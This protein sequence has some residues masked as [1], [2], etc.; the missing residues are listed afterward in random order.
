MM[1]V[2]EAWRARASEAL[3][4]LPSPPFV[5]VHPSTSP[6]PIT[7]IA[8]RPSS[9]FAIRCRDTGPTNS[10][11][12]NR[13]RDFCTYPA[14]SWSSSSQV[15]HGHPASSARLYLQGTTSRLYCMH[16]KS[17]ARLPGSCSF[18]R[19]W[20]LA[21]WRRVFDT[22]AIRLWH[23]PCALPR[24]LPACSWTFAHD[25]LQTRLSLG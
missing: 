5:T 17:L 25:S 20:T 21:S 24:W 9:I 22:E 16:W 10:L 18:A 19:R 6:G 4:E 23:A 7:S 11:P 1:S 15:L 8:F 12:K 13:L 2:P 14:P 3:G